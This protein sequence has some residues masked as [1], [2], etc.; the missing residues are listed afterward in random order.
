MFVGPTTYLVTTPYNVA[1]KLIQII[2]NDI[3]S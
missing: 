1:T 3:I 2:T